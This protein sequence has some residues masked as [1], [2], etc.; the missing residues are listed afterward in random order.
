[1][2]DSTITEI[3]GYQLTDLLGEG[4]MGKVWRAEHPIL[5]T[6]MAVK[7]LDATLARDEALVERFLS[8]AKIQVQLRHPNIVKVENVSS[9]SV[10]MLMEYIEGDTL[11]AMLLNEGNSVGTLLVLMRQ[12]LSAVAF[13]HGK[14]VVH[15][16][17]KPSNVM[18]TQDGVAKVCDF[19]IAKIVGSGGKT[20]TGASFGTP[21]YMSPEQVK[22]SKDVDTRA[23]IYSLGVILYELLAGR[24]P[25]QCG[26]DTD[27]DYEVMEGHVRQPPPDIRRFNSKVP[28]V[29]VMVVMKALEKNPDERYQ[30]VAAFDEALAVA[31][32]K[33]EAFAATTA[34]THAAVAQLPADSKPETEFALPAF[35]T[36]AP[37]SNP[38]LEKKQETKSEPA[39]GAKVSAIIAVVVV[40]IVAGGLGFAF[41]NKGGDAKTENA[42]PSTEAAPTEQDVASA[43]P[44]DVV[45]VAV[46]DVTPSEPEEVEPDTTAVAVPEPDLV[47]LAPVEERGFDELKKAAFSEMR[48]HNG[49][50]SAELFRKALELNNDPNTRFLLGTA[51]EMAE[52]PCEALVEYRQCFKDS[53]GQKEEAFTR[54][55]AMMALCPNR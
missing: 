13:A 47:E 46:V 11:S 28:D 19:G 10:A 41:M 53:K 7:I 24:P 39:K 34:P 37:K 2:T 38:A 21:A 32:A 20:R 23:D 54:A 44:A 50:A 27:S 55:E 6:V 8:E 30:T 29:L 31:V 9:S 40:L 1:M 45:G 3:L 36:S 52:K 51:L 18:V 16:D 17:L 12:V 33:A 4:G 43:E 14:G 35:K 49:D 26:E 15:R 48:Q 42:T 25:F 5:G 22:G